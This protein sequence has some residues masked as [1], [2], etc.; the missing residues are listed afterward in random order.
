MKRKPHRNDLKIGTVVHVVLDSLAK[1]TGFR[2]K[3]SRSGLRF[4]CRL[5]PAN[6]KLCRNTAGFKQ[7]N[8]LRKVHPTL[9]KLLF[10]N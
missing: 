5:L 2:L 7:Y 3:R 10:K 8:S 6:Q 4:G 9:G 1:P